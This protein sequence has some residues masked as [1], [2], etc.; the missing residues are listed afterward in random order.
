MSII[1]RPD[2]T[3]APAFDVVVAGLLLDGSADSASQTYVVPASLPSD[4]R[5]II[6]STRESLWPYTLL[7]STVAIGLAV[8]T[9]EHEESTRSWPGTEVASKTM[10]TSGAV[11]KEVAERMMKRMSTVSSAAEL[12]LSQ[13]EELATE[14]CREIAE[15]T[16]AGAAGT[17]KVKA[18]RSQLSELLEH[19][20]ELARNLLNQR[21]PALDNIR[22]LGD[23]TAKLL[24][25]VHASTPSRS[26]SS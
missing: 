21:L 20:A 6:V 25:R 1:I 9:A 24:G 3:G 22:A 7:A 26:R 18:L 11:R 5:R 16:T 17:T 2:T 14:L 13:T 4:E 10:R 15:A 19:E 8:E 23:V 12:R